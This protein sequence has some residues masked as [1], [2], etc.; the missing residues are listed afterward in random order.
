MPI[1]QKVSSSRTGFHYLITGSLSVCLF[2]CVTFVVFTDCESCTRLISANPGSMEAGEYRL[3]R[4]A[5]FVVRRLVVVAVAS[6]LWISWCVLGATGFRVFS[7]VL[8]FFERTR[9]AAR[10]RPPCPIYL[11]PSIKKMYIF[12]LHSA[13]GKKA[14][15]L[16]GAYRV[17]ACLFV[18]L[19]V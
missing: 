19:S 13:Y 7:L 4:Q 12:C 6:L 3:T 2:V 18:C 15:S 9:P 8:F 11:S 10:M 14:S 16:R 17:P 5:S 1:G